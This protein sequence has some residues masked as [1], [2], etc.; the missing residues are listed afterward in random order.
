M[1]PPRP[2][3]FGST[4]YAYDAVGN[5]TQKISTPVGGTATTETYT[6]ATTS[7]RLNTV[8]DGT[9]TR[10]FSYDA[11]G[12][13][14]TDNRGTGTTYTLVYGEHGRMTQLKQGTTVLA[15]YTYDAA[16]RRAIRVAGAT[17][18]HYQF[19]HVAGGGGKLLAESDATG[20]V[21]REYVWLGSMPLA[22]IDTTGSGGGATI[23]VYY[24]HPNHLGA[25]H[26]ITDGAKLV[27]WDGKFTPFGKAHAIA[28]SLSH[29]R[30]FPGQYHD[31]AAG[32][33]QNHRRDYDPSIGRYLQSDPIGLSGGLNTYAY[34]SNNPQN[35]IDPTGERAVCVPCAVAGGALVV[36]LARAL[37]R[38]AVR[39]AVRGACR[40][41]AKS[42]AKQHARA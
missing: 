16:D 36:A 1:V 4:S 30:R 5:R 28:G 3:A 7:N 21:Q 18:T 39:K 32:Y 17:T 13:V 24:T 31:S 2:G 33:V 25:S 11:N 10:T 15:S 38:A 9:I 27:V 8:A 20:A 22:R 35:L 26:K 29:D 23:A 34:V 12:S 40:A 6:Y 14:T 37:L 19:G 42:G 41:A